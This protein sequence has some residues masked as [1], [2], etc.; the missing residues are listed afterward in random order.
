MDSPSQTSIADHNYN[1]TQTSTD[2]D[3]INANDTTAREM[4]GSYEKDQQKLMAQLKE[5]EQELEESK[6]ELKV[7]IFFL[8]NILALVHFKRP[9]IFVFSRRKKIAENQISRGIF[10]LEVE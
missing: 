3:Y 1:A 5:A 9:D 2:H 10:L 8:I 6:Q 7:Y 4:S